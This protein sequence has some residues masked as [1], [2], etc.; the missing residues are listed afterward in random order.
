MKNAL[1]IMPDFYGYAKNIRAEFHNQGYEVDLFYE[2]PPTIV[3]LTLRK[4]ERIFKTRFVYQFFLNSLYRRIHQ[5]G[6]KYDFFLVIRGN[7]LNEGFIE[8]VSNN[9]MKDCAK[10]VYY[11]WDSF[12]FLDHHGA[13]GDFFDAKYS[14]DSEDVK[15]NSSWTLLPLFYTAD[16]DVDR[17][18]QI[19]EK[20]YDLSCIACF[21]EERY[22]ILE[23]IR[24]ANPTLNLKICLYIS[25]DLYDVKIK[26]NP[27]FKKINTEWLIF[28]FLDTK[29]VADINL[30]SKAILDITA[31]SQSGLSMRTVE[32]VGLRRKL[33]TTN[34]SVLEYNISENAVCMFNDNYII[35]KEWL[36]AD[37]RIDDTIRAE[38][39][40]GNWVNII[41]GYKD[42]ICENSTYNRHS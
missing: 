9:C 19:P 3:F 8:K 35:D 28:N 31:N 30:K 14:F 22:K 11:T 33:I 6:K 21:N 1:I 4:I 34:P 23:K 24:Q 7:I 12:R 37:F 27:F 26:I 2:E 15:N 32:S 10:R 13:L 17:I 29:E 40:L 18:K 42:A 16:F 5:T 41:L 36:D 39:S 25:K 20:V 38:Y